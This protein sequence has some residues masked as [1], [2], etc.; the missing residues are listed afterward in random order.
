MRLPSLLGRLAPALL[1]LVPALA[2]ARV[3]EVLFV[4]GSARVESAAHGPAELLKGSA[5]D[6]GDRVITGSNG[7][8]QIRMD[9]GGL[10]VLRP[11]SELVIEQFH[12]PVAMEGSSAATQT[13]RSLMSLVR[14]GFRAI[15]GTLG[16]ANPEACEMRTPV[17]T[18]GIRGT[19]YS[20]LYCAADC[21]DLGLE[22][23]LYVGV[24]DGTIF[25]AN[26]AGG[27]ELSKGQYGFVE[28]EHTAPVTSTSPG[29]GAALALA[30]QGVRATDGDA[31]LQLAPGG[32]MIV[33]APALTG[34][35]GTPE[36]PI[37]ADDGTESGLDLSTGA[38]GGVVLTYAGT[39]GT[40]FS[41]VTPAGASGAVADADGNLIAFSG[42][43]PAGTGRLEHR[44][45]VNL[46]A[47]RDSDR[48]DATG[49]RWGRWSGGSVVTTV[50]GA[51]QTSA[52][53]SESVHWIAP[54]G[55]AQP[56][57]PSTG[58]ASF[59]LIGNTNPTDA[60]GHAGTLGSAT[61][62]ADF[63]A[64]T[65]DAD[66]SLSLAPT[67]Q[68]W[69]A[70]A[71]AVPMN[72]SQATFGGA[73]DSVTVRGADSTRSGSGTLSGFFTGDT[74]GALLGAGMSYGLSDGI[75]N[76]AGTAA[77]QRVRPGN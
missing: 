46:D 18:I 22:P 69:N 25:V 45:G 7:R 16:K 26:A 9:D 10:I 23:G 58:R 71:S 63:S 17:A 53:D 42:M 57:L 5:L 47:G 4:Y 2:W 31:P 36:L 49:L 8:L 48:S 62:A 19:D 56:E 11:L 38:L 54:G 27:I 43:T 65:V 6:E 44:G 30:N 39:P 59:E 41:A 66:L 74:H 21:G 37:V 28:D 61:L 29:A 60:S 64:R 33:Q 13:P 75:T 55:G 32:P 3:G 40:P 76:I 35:A 77:F 14:G 12:Y 51:E 24:V 73:F 52:L 1:S 68:V 15:T 20:A 72:A 34:A 70:S 50:G 67:G